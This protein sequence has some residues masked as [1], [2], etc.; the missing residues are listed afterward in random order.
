MQRVMVGMFGSKLICILNGGQARGTQPT[1]WCNSF[2]LGHG[3]Q[4][5][6]YKIVSDGFR[7]EWILFRP[8]ALMN[9]TGTR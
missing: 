4:N 8:S 1:L 2:R 6:I 9:R 5:A 3:I 7:V